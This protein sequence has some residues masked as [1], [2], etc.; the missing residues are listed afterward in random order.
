MMTYFDT[1]RSGDIDFDEFLLL[2]QAIVPLREV[3]DYVIGKIVCTDP[4]PKDC[5]P[6]MIALL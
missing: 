5:V 2:M 1:D 6:I 4:F 3:M